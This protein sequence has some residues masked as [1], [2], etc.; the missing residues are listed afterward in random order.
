MPFRCP[1]CGR[2]LYNRRR[3]TCEFCGTE[4]PAA[5]RLTDRQ[6]AFVEGLKRAEAEHHRQFMQHPPGGSGVGTSLGTDLGIGFAW[7]GVDLG[8]D[9]IGGLDAG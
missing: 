8:V 7:G 1:K 5:L 6:I 2:P 9:A 4:I 3:K